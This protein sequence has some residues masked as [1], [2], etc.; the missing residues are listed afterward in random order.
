MLLML[1]HKKCSMGEIFASVLLIT[2]AYK[3][4]DNQSSMP[5]EPRHALNV[6]RGNDLGGQ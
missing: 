2:F 5:T 1:V 6:R 3:E 4:V